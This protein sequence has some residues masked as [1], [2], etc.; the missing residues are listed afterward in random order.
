MSKKIVIISASPRKAG[1]TDLLCDSFAR[2]AIEAGHQVEKIFIQEKQINYCTGCG[3][4]VANNHSGCIQKDDMNAIVDKLL[5][6]DTIVMATPI[7]FYTMNGQM[8]TFID[9]CCGQYTNLLDKE[10][11]F[12]MAAA[13]SR[14]TIFNR[15]LEEFHGFLDCLDGSVEKGHIAAGGV[16]KKGDVQNT[17]FVDTAYKM[18]KSV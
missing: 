11:Y 7:Y 10:F 12:I 18:G 3:A 6:A 1:N 16:W 13:D 17:A 15:T 5:A 2:G 8:K 4:C 14:K 9:R